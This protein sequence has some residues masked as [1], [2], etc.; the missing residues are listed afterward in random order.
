MKDFG[1]TDKYIKENIGSIQKFANALS[2]ASRKAQEAKAALKENFQFQD[3]DPDAKIKT[4]HKEHTGKMR[5]A[6]NAGDIVVLKKEYD[7]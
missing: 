7:E 6:A 3:T 4:I 5:T 1:A 2:D